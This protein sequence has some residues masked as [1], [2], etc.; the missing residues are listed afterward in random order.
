MRGQ[1]RLDP[2]RKK[3]GW[4]QRLHGIVEFLWVEQR[5][6]WTGAVIRAVLRECRCCGASKTVASRD[7]RMKS[8][9][10]SSVINDLIEFDWASSICE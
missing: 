8:N 3:G 6:E 10:R 5:S 1:R 7:A 2:R 4:R 9:L